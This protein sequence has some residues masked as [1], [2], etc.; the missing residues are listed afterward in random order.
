MPA[1]RLAA[2]IQ[3]IV[4]AYLFPDAQR[5]Y[6]ADSQQILFPEAAEPRRIGSWRVGCSSLTA[7]ATPG[8]FE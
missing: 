1:R 5:P 8:T 7:G 6:G 2:I 3:P 4:A